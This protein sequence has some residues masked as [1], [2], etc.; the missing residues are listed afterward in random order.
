MDVR[1]LSSIRDI[2]PEHWNSLLGCDYPFLQHAFLLALEESGSVC[3]ESGWQ[4]C[5]LI[6]EQGGILEAG[7][8]LYL[9]NHSWGEYV[10]DWSWAEAYQR[11]GQPYYPKLVSAVPFT[12]AS[13]PRLLTA[14]HA[15]RHQ[16]AQASITAIQA[17]AIDIQASG[18]HLLFPSHYDDTLLREQPLQR[19]TGTQFHWYN[20]RYQSFDHFLQQLSSRRRKAIKKER[21]RAQS[22]GFTMTMQPGSELSEQFWDDFYL[23]YHRTYLKRSGGT[24]YLNRA[25]FQQIAETMADQLLMATAIQDGELIAAALFFRDRDNLY[26]RYW[27][28][29]QEFDGLHF[30]L[31]YYLGIEYAIRE[32]LDRFDAGAQ[33]EHKI[34]RGFE[35]VETCSYHWL[36]D[37]RFDQAIDAFLSEEHR[38]NKLYMADARNHLPYKHLKSCQL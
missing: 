35:P 36:A 5:H 21:A 30:E 9:K 22:Q 19:R 27:G 16:V 11:I 37:P 7:L 26:G 4:P 28:A 24:G 8:P 10:F 13:G 3:A 6:L 2:A 31:C 18:L 33:G 32:Q 1:F 17:Y 34:K 20:Q 29:R 25:F 14:D 12:P 38:L 15:D 23:L